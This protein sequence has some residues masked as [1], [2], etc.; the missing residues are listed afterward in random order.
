[1]KALIK[2]IVSL[3]LLGLFGGLALAA[4][5]D[6]DGIDDSVDVCPNTP[7]LEVNDVATSGANIGCTVTPER[8]AE[9]SPFVANDA[10]NVNVGQLQ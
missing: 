1:M 2:I 6:A 9:A 7:F 3:V 5:S 4:D 8:E 10:N